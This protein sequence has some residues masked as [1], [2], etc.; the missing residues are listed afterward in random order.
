MKEEYVKKV[1]EDFCSEESGTSANS[2]KDYL[3]AAIQ[4]DES[5]SEKP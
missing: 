4:N 1:Y 5:H 2:F 3:I